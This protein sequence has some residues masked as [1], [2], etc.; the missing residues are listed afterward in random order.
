MQWRLITPGVML[1]VGCGIPTAVSYIHSAEQHQAAHA[2]D[3]RIAEQLQL[4]RELPGNPPDVV[5]ALTEFIGEGGQDADATACLMFSPIAA[6]QLAATQNTTSCPTAI[7]ALHDQVT[8]PG[9]YIN[10]VTIPA[11]TWSTTGNIGSID[12]CAV[13]WNGLFVEEPLTSPGPRPGHLTLTR[14][15]SMGWLITGYQ[16]C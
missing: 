4:A 3:A 14:Q 12:G 15:D 16:G 10:A 1:V 13:T 2:A 5:V 6:N 7:Q 8:D 11:D 9:T